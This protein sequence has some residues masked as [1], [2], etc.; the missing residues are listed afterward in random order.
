MKEGCELILGSVPSHPITS[1]IKEY[2]EDELIEKCR[3]VDAI[4]STP[5][6]PLTKKVLSSARRLFCI[7]QRGIGVDNVD[8]ETACGL[9][10]LVTNAPIELEFVGVAEHM[11]AL[12]LALA[13]K[14]KTVSNLLRLGASAYFNELVNTV[15]LK[16]KTVGIIGLGRIGTRVAALLRPFNVRLLG[17]VR[18]RDWE[19]AKSLGVQLVDLDVLLAESDFVTIHVP[20]TAQTRHM[21]G[22]KELALMKN[23]AYIINTARG[24]II[25]EVALIN[26]LKSGKI[27]GAALDVFEKEPITPDN[28]LLKMDNVIITPHIAGRNSETLIEGEKLAVEN[29]LKLLKGIIPEHVI[30]PNAIPKWKERMNI[31]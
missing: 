17:Y 1:E 14:L 19:K 20:L 21:I 16:G 5:R 30:N 31:L 25:D 22:E 2:T 13:K 23:T 28:P 6:L 8:I 12:I 9:G 24:A 18:T 7:C 27:A 10:V 26:A 11:V 3:D 29:C 4:L 15:T